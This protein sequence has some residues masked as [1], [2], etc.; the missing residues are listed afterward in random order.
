M[1]TAVIGTVISSIE[2]NDTLT[3]RLH[4]QKILLHIGKFQVETNHYLQ[5]HQQHFDPT[6]DLI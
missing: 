5:N 1:T 6:I 3:E 4:K 2:C